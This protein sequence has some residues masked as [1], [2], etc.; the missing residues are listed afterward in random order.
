MLDQN[1]VGATRGGVHELTR[2]LGEVRR[3]DDGHGERYDVRSTDAQ[4][5][6]GQIRPV[7]ELV[8][9]SL[10]ARSRLL[11]DVRIVVDHV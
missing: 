8:E 7:V 2:K 1:R 6:R 3:V 11:R 9:S 5:A 10:D 4:A